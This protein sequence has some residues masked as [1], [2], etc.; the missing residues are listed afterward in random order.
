MSR[1]PVCGPLLT[2]TICA[3][4]G[5]LCGGR[6]MDPLPQGCGLAPLPEHL[7]GLVCDRPRGWVVQRCCHGSPHVRDPPLCVIC[8]LPTSKQGIV[9]RGDVWEACACTSR[10]SM[11]PAH[12]RAVSHQLLHA[13]SGGSKPHCSPRR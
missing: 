13:P 11:R 12:A 6:G 3:P 9:W 2:L 4:A 1:L 10:T 7:R 5:G 8:P